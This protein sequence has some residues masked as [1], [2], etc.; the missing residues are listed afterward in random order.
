MAA[1][2]PPA[3]GGGDA[4]GVGTGGV[5]VRSLK[6]FDVLLVHGFAP[7]VLLGAAVAVVLLAV[8]GA[9]GVQQEYGLAPAWPV[10]VPG[11][12]AE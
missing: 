7:A 5:P 3:I 4:A 10:R 11:S 2:P 12:A 6:A 1:A 8:Y 9:W